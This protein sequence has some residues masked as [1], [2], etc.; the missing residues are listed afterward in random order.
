[1]GHGAQVVHSDQDF[2]GPGIDVVIGDR[3]KKLDPGAP[4]RMKL[5]TAV[6]SCS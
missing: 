5:P 1:M 4:N 2:T 3:F 6:T